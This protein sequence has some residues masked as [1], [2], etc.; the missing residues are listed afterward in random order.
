MLDGV[1]SDES[2]ISEPERNFVT[3]AIDRA[4]GW[5]KK[6][7]TRRVENEEGVTI[8]QDGEARSPRLVSYRTVDLLMAAQG[9]RVPLP[10]LVKALARSTITDG[11]GCD[12]SPDDDEVLKLNMAT[13]RQ[14]E[15]ISVKSPCLSPQNG[16]GIV[17]NTAPRTKPTNNRHS[18][19]ASNA[20]N[21]WRSSL[22][23]ASSQ[24]QD[25]GNVMLVHMNPTPFNSLPP[26]LAAYMIIPPDDDDSES[27]NQKLIFAIPTLPDEVLEPQGRTL[28]P[29]CGCSIPSEVK[30]VTIF[31]HREPDDSDM[32]SDVYISVFL[33]SP[34]WA[35][36]VLALAVVSSSCVHPVVAKLH[37][38]ANND[39][40]VG[41]WWAIGEAL[42]FIILILFTLFTHKWTRSERLFFAGSGTP[43][44]ILQLS[45]LGL[46]SGGEGA[47]WVG[48]FTG[49]GL[50]VQVFYYLY[51][52]SF[53]HK[54]NYY[55]SNKTTA[56]C[57]PRT[58]PA[59]HTSLEAYKTS[60][61]VPWRVF[62]CI[63]II[64]MIFILRWYF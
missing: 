35:W 55:S 25:P 1:P 5:L 36:L 15:D 24:D 39:S 37:K 32:F 63:Y 18:L 9:L 23:E 29:L 49:K 20:F 51:N 17:L 52:I 45:L 6:K 14:Q 62:W 16:F 21:R 31:Q 4:R 7:R 41:V 33:T 56:I 47:S 57:P 2:S 26:Q 50:T 22:R 30:T 11:T 58:S 19:G 12:V 8:G 44:G 43:W 53:V 60:I 3:S 28:L 38:Y 46:L 54:L 34:P 59:S 64:G 42:G 61:C 10:A 27:G 13:Q 48:A 40:L